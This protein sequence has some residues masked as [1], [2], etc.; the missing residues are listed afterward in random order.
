MDQTVSGMVS[1]KAT[2]NNSVKN[3]Y[4]VR[5][6]DL[7]VVQIEPRSWLGRGGVR[8]DSHNE[9]LFASYN[10]YQTEI[11]TSTIYS[12]IRAADAV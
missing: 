5:E 8:V 2:K 7:G 9:R 1:S 11:S 12:Q 6:S 10:K 4:K 3:H